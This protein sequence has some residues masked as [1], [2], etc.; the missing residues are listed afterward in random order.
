MDDFS[1]AFDTMA[2]TIFVKFK[3]NGDIVEQRG[4][5]KKI[6]TWK[7][8]KA[9]KSLGQLAAFQFKTSK[10]FGYPNLSCTAATRERAY[11]IWRE[12]MEGRFIPKPKI[13]KPAVKG[14]WMSALQVE[15]CKGMKVRL[16][17]SSLLPQYRT[18]EHMIGIA[19]GG[20]GCKRDGSGQKVYIEFDH[21]MNETWSKY[22]LDQVF[23]P[24]PEPAEGQII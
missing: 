10:E 23:V 2:F 16:K 19:I 4:E 22:D 17:A 24:D 7:K 11:Q 1:K 8:L 18:D 21:G 5:Q 12:M 9:N 13:E 15:D 20:F 3:R 14:K 6:G